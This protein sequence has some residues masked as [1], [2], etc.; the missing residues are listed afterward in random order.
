M[1]TCPALNVSDA[2]PNNTDTYYTITVFV[3]C[4]S[5]YAIDPLNYLN[6][7]VSTTCTAEGSWSVYPIICQRT[8]KY[9][10]WPNINQLTFVTSSMLLTQC[11]PAAYV[12][13]NAYF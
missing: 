2:R 6:N 5:G 3:T 1:A 11:G 8:T 9:V 12:T 10:Y 7:S 4:N 13:R